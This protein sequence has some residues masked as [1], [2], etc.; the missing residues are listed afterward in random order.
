MWRARNSAALCPGSNVHFAINPSVSS[1]LQERTCLV[2]RQ[3]RESRVQRAWITVPKVTE[4]IRFDV[5]F[6]EELLLTSETRL[7][8]GKELF[9][10]LGVIEPGHGSAI[11]TEGPRGHDQ[12]RA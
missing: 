4:E 1:A 11:E 10:H 12:V 7:P 8:G 3:P 2:E 6:R 9:V 5:P